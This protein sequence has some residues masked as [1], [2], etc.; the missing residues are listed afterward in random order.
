MRLEGLCE[1]QEAGIFAFV[2]RVAGG[3]SSDF[4]HEAAGN[5][6]LLAEA[7][8]ECRRQAWEFDT[9]ESLAE[10]SL[11]LGR[12]PAGGPGPPVAGLP[13]VRAVGRSLPGVSFA[14]AACAG[15]LPSAVQP[16]ACRGN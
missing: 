6:V 12:F 11:A 14:E 2:H 9:L 1:P 3:G 8:E 15:P 10:G 4:S 16:H 7:V 13:Q 5:F